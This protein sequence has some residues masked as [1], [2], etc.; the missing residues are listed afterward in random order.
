MPGGMST[1]SVMESESAKPRPE[2]PTAAEARAALNALDA[3]G[4]V[5]AERVVTPWW[6]HL[7]L[8][9]IV[10]AMTGAQALAGPLAMVVIAIAVVA[11]PVLTLAH[12]R[13]SGV[14]ISEPGGNR[15]RRVLIASIAVLV[16]GMAAAF[17]L[18][19]LEVPS[20]WVLVA[21]LIAGISTVLLS[22]AYDGALR[23]ELAR[24]TDRKP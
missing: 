11:I 21:A 12:S 13:Q 22:R 9:G 2:R 18:R 14:S 15:S 4:A 1:L 17:V 19:V 3:D 7:G 20:W 6:Y 24:H 10:F 23:T 5:L 8:A 16:L